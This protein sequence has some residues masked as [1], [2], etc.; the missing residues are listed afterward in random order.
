MEDD[1]EFGDLYTDVLTPFSTSSTPSALQRQTIPA[2]TVNRP[3]DI[4]LRSNDADVPYASSN[5]EFTGSFRNQT[6]IS[7]RQK[8]Q[9]D[10]GIIQFAE[11]HPSSK[12][13]GELEDQLESENKVLVAVSE[14][15]GVDSRKDGI[16]SRVLEGG[17]VNFGVEEDDGSSRD[18]KDGEFGLKEENFGIEVEEE[19]NRRLMGHF[20]TQQIIP[21]LDAGP[22]FQ[23]N[24]DKDKENHEQGN[25]TRREDV[26]GAE[27]DG[28]DSD[29]EDDLQI[30]LNDSNHGPMTME[31]NNGLVGSDEDEDGDPLVIIADNDAAHQP[32]EEQEWGEDMGQVADGERKD[33]AEAVKANGGVAVAPKIVYGNFGYQPYH[34]QFKYVRPGAAPLPGA[35][36]I[37]PGGAPGQ[38]R[39]PMITAAIA[40]RARGDWRPTGLKGAPPMQKGF[41]PG[42][43]GNNTSGRGLEFTLPSHKTIFEVDI[44]GFEEK[45]WKYPG[46]DVSEFFNFGLNEDSWKE[47]CKQLEQ[48]RFESTMQSRIH[49]YETSRANQEYDPDLP[50]E[51]AAAAGINP[52]T[53]NANASK[54]DGGQNELVKGTARVR[55]PLPMGRTIPVEGGYGERLPSVDTRPPRYRDSD[56]IIEIVLQDSVEDDS[57]TVDAVQKQADPDNSEDKGAD[58]VQENNTEVGNECS[59]EYPVTFDGTKGDDIMKSSTP[60]NSLHDE[61]P[62]E[63]RD[64]PLLP[65]SP[66]EHHTGSRG[67]S[68]AYSAED[69]GT[70]CEDRKRLTEE[71]SRGLDEKSQ[72]GPLEESIETINRKHTPESFSPASSRGH[73]FEEKIASDDESIP[74]EVKPEREKEETDSKRVAPANASKDKNKHHSIRKQKLSSQVEPLSVK[75]TDDGGDFKAGRSSENSKATGSSRDHEKW[76]DG[77]DEEV[78]QDG[79]PTY[80]RD[81]KRHRGEDVH[82]LRRKDRDGRL[83]S[84]RSYVLANG[85]EDPYA[86][87]EWDPYAAHHFH[88]KAEVF[89]RRKERDYSDGTW[90]RRDDDQHSRRVRAEDQRKHERADEMVPRHRGKMRENDKDEQYSRKPLDNGSWRGYDKGVRY[91][92]KDDHLKSHYENLN[93]INN[94]R[95]KDD[96][97]VR[98]DKVDKEENLN[99][100]RETTSR[101]K[102]ERD[103]SLDLRKRD[104]QQR[105]D[106]TDAHHSVRHKDEPWLQRDRTERQRERDEWH[107]SKQSY[108]ENLLRRDREDGRGSIRIGRNTDEKTWVSHSRV[109]D[110]YK[111]Y[112]KDSRNKDAGRH[113]EMLKRKERV[114]DESNLQL[115][116]SE[117][118]YARASQ[119]N[120]E[121]KRSR[122]ER[123]S[124]RNDRSVHATDSQ[125]VNEKRH[126]ENSR[127]VKESEGSQH[128]SSGPFKKHQEGRA[129]ASEMAG[130]KGTG[131]QGNNEHS[132]SV[133]DHLTK[134][135]REDVSSDDEQLGSKRGRSKLERW[136]SHKER[137]FLT[138]AK[139]SSSLKGKETDTDNGGGSRLSTKASEVSS[140]KIE[141]VDNGNS[142][143]EGMD[144]GGTDSKDTDSKPMEDRHLD[145]VAKLKKRSERF[146]LPMPSEK[147]AV[148]VKRL[149][150]EPLPSSQSEIPANSEVKQERPARKRRWI[151]N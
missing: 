90:Q 67:Q 111:G 135:H 107:P 35:P 1:D 26:S 24:S 3:I 28:W 7:E 149:E 51:L 138:S 47:Y 151:S 46:V 114:D 4:K 57:S 70:S 40:G 33:T 10:G 58:V 150:S 108:E 88:G 62:K 134:E 121:E 76:S 52:P 137:T 103:E 77:V 43:W 122:Q 82:G 106:N 25:S 17:D 20:D 99:A 21:G 79:R 49:V 132:Y 11:S 31:R 145:T 95:R 80:P 54:I 101:Q 50:P 119:L 104:D 59:N 85:R 19:D 5:S 6:P 71:R 141:G 29:S 97:T 81:L 143:P 12:P 18:R 93:D 78:L 64:S 118:V 36:P 124:A 56:A 61:I 27:G 116:S 129:G 87:R 2:T 127:K 72:D 22:F 48:L 13:F 32:I 41:H 44:D 84:E 65:D 89:D 146:K 92:E 131:E 68:P 133:Q 34:S 23:G 142:L 55:P 53:D 73:S 115:R 96:D 148:A 109:K 86:H 9:S 69:D 126:K 100:H 8:Q 39:P 110:D 63:E 94:R 83:E 75:G 147:D 112:D 125:R 136:T 74:A 113:G 123:S 45:P 15:W 91:R 30:V 105:K 37:G 117:D 42:F 102:R 128:C 130:L 38:V 140:R 144:A 60:V 66:V 16:G 98:R 139:S 120:N 14:G